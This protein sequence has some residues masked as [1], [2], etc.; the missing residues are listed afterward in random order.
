MRELAESLY[1]YKSVHF[2]EGVEWE[3]GLATSRPSLN[4]L[5]RHKKSTLSRSTASQESVRIVKTSRM[6]GCWLWDL[7]TA[8]R[9]KDGFRSWYYPKFTFYGDTIIWKWNSWQGKYSMAIIFPTYSLVVSIW[10]ITLVS[11]ISWLNAELQ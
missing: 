1:R 7:Y 8:D 3:E 9:L 5:A 2:I 6:F 11:R 10:P 4:T